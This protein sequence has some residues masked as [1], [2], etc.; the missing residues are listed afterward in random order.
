MFLIFRKY[1]WINM[2]KK[3]SAVVVRN[4]PFCCFMLSLFIP[5]GV[6]LIFTIQ[7]FISRNPKRQV[8]KPKISR[9]GW[10]PDLPDHRDFSYA[11]PRAM[12]R[13]LPLKADLR[14]SCPPVYDQ[15]DLGSCTANAIGAAFQFGQMK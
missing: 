2:G 9:Y 4:S 6:I 5:F 14:S 8:M 10:Q 11:A 1:F 7:E 3:V 15:G 12:L 13:K